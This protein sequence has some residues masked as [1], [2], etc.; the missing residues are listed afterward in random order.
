LL[1]KLIAALLAFGPFGLLA[2]AVID[3]LGIPLPGAMDFL[4]VAF[5]VKEP[6]HAYFAALLAVIGSTSGNVALFMATRHGTRWFIKS[7]PSSPKGQKFH[8]WFRKYGLLTVFIPA[9][10]PVVPF[11]LKVFVMSAGYLRTHFGRFLAVVLV[12]RIIRY[13]GEAYLALQVGEHAEAFLRRNAW[14][15][16]GAALAMATGLYLL[17]RYS[18]RRGESVL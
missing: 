5:A 1:H 14:P 3:S 8:R 7:E 13:F 17:L 12:A 10:T 18:E 9:V 15:L 11:P 6:E 16:L 4:L 2:I